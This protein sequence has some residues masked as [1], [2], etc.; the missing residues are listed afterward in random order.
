MVINRTDKAGETEKELL[1]L[2]QA[3]FIF[4]EFEDNEK[5]KI[6]LSNIGA[7]MMQK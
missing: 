2:S 3:Y 1:Q 4:D 5:V 6:C 7:I